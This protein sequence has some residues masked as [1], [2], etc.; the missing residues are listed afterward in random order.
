MIKHKS[1]AYAD[2]VVK[3][4]IP[5]PKYVMKQCEAFL[6]ICDGKDEKHFLQLGP[7]LQKF[8]HN[9]NFIDTNSDS[10]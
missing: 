5:A 2:K 8:T 1:Y 4:E 6:K 7:A 3:N 9:F 10:K